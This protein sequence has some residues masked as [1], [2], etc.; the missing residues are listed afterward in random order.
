MGRQRPNKKE[1]A[2]MKVMTNLGESPT[3]IAKKMGKSHHT[4][5]K[6]LDDLEIHQDPEVK[7]LIIIITEKELQDLKLLNMK[8]RKNLHYR[9]DTSSPNVI[10]SLATMDKSF[11]QIRLLE[12]KSTQNININALLDRKKELEKMLKEGAVKEDV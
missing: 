12:N 5:Q 10:E 3:S 4:V 8:A 1:I 2:E 9:F 6:Y 7:K 11:Q